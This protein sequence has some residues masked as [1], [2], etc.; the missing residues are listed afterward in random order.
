MPYIVTYDGRTI[1]YPICT[2]PND[3]IKLDLQTGEI[4]DSFKLEQ[5]NL[6]MITGRTNMSRLTTNTHKHDGGFATA[7]LRDSKGHLFATW[8]GYAFFVSK[9]TG[10]HCP[11]AKALRRA[12]SDNR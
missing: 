2:F 6:A 10:S 5:G 9:P 4:V 12:F 3:T 7:H 8:L 1:G 11:S